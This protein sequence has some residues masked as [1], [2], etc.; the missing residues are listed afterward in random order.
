MGAADLPLETH[1]I[2]AGDGVTLSVQVAGEGPAVV[3]A[4]GIG[5]RHPGWARFVTHLRRRRRV[6]CWDY[7]GVGG[8]AADARRTGF[9]M[10]RHGWDALEILDA[11]G[12]E[13]AAVVGWSMGVPVGLEMIRAAP[14]RVTHFA[15]L[16]GA[17]GRPFRTGFP[18]P[19]GLAVEGVAAISFRVTRPS[20]AVMDLAARFPRLTHAALAT[21]RFTG[22]DVD[23]DLFAADVES[24]AGAPKDA[25][26][27]TML[28]LARHDASDLLPGIAIPTLVVGGGRDWLTPPAASRAM[29]DAIPGARLLLLPE[30]THFGLMEQPEA[31]LAAVDALLAQSPAST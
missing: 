18:L 10:S 27:R 11:L 5:V 20:Q 16:F 12:E 1:R 9:A 31:I 23:R 29:A 13:R 17:P 28:A 25:Y 7:R 15:A 26:F 22:R 6:I 30:A 21:L 19:I 2:R 14:R 24:V 4:N 3:L 8:S